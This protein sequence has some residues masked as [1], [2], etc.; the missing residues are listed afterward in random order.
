MCGVK[1]PLLNSSALS[2]TFTTT[3]D[4][5]TRW[6]SS[7]QGDNC[8]LEMRNRSYRSTCHLE[9]ELFYALPYLWPSTNMYS[10]LRLKGQGPLP[11]NLCSRAN[12]VWRW[13]ALF[14]FFPNSSIHFFFHECKHLRSGQED[15]IVIYFTQTS[16]NRPGPLCGTLCFL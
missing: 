16:W 8:P 7:R 5:M 13:P 1:T 15:G 4:W 12:T 14:K 11:T 3:S 2:V 6:L 9:R 10:A